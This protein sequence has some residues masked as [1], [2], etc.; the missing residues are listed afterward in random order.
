M[1]LQKQLLLIS[2]SIFI[3]PWA[4]CQ[5]VKEMDNTLREGQITSLKAQ[6]RAIA[7][8]LQ[9][10]QLS[11]EILT[12]SNVDNAD[13]SQQIYFHHLTNQPF[14]DGY[15]SDWPSLSTAVNSRRFYYEENNDDFYYDLNTGIYNDT[16]YLDFSIS[17][18]TRQFHNPQKLGIANGDHIILH[19]KDKFFR[20]VDY[21]LR[22]SG[23]GNFIAYYQSSTETIQAESAIK[24]FWRETSTGYAVEVQFPFSLINHYLTI[25]YFD[26]NNLN[27]NNSENSS[28]P[29]KVIQYSPELQNMLSPYAE[30]G[31]SIRIV[32]RN[33]WLLAKTKNN[34]L[35]RSFDDSTFWLIKWLYK[36]ILDKKHLPNLDNQKTDGKFSFDDTEK[37]FSDDQTYT[38]YR[39]GSEPVARVTAPIHNTNASSR[40]IN[41]NIA[42]L[43]ILEQTASSVAAATNAAFN[44]L[45]LITLGAMAFVTMTL[46][47]YASLLSFRIRR[48]RNATDNAVG[49]DGKINQNFITT[50]AKDEVGDLTRSYKQL[51]E[52][53]NDYT[54]YLRTLASK[55]SHELRTP[56]AVIKSSIDNLDQSL[57]DKNNDINHSQ[58]IR[59]ASEGAERLSNILNAMSAANRIEESIHDTQTTHF[60]LNELLEELIA[61]YQ[62]TYPEKRIE[63]KIKKVAIDDK[64]QTHPFMMNG[65][66]DLIVQML[67]KLIDNA[68]DF[69]T[70][71]GIISFELTRLNGAH[72]SLI[73]SVANSGP[74][75]PSHMQ[76]QL[77]DSLVSLRDENTQNSVS[78]PKTHLGLGL[79]IVRLIANFHQ[80]H[81]TARNLDDETGV[82][83]SV[84]LPAAEAP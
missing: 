71:D 44:R 31:M 30:P 8:T 63:L 60:Q 66:P 43:V 79:H 6:A 3:L 19:T 24:G 18:N 47:T 75:L 36:I 20:R 35:S 29:I 46:L 45:F 49:S 17:D 21:I 78:A 48:L 59:R 82:M 69:C 83:L 40:E 25:S 33:Q 56:L 53:L 73:L 41:K 51:L 12:S 42:G 68:V 16:A 81:V 11:Q 32:D 13:P 27:K 26:K 84:E 22:N 23:S 52:R 62:A 67:D 50:S 9:N 14:I 64:K 70:D 58:Y 2:L 4:G 74:L 57:S 10:S 34:S 61:A 37:Y 54:E 7:I 15:N 72:A 1:T 28:S 77:F 80:G 38:W 65:S 5:F 55:L 76:G 39:L